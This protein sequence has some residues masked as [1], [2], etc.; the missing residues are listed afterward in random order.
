MLLGT[1]HESRGLPQS[2]ASRVRQIQFTD[3]QAHWMLKD[4]LNMTNT[5][6]T[7]TQADRLRNSIVCRATPSMPVLNV[8]ELETE[9]ASSSLSLLVIKNA[10]MLLEKSGFNIKT[11]VKARELVQEALAIY[12]I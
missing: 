9:A 7:N 5:L 8:D 2:R 11:D 3:M 1:S 10:L 6:L 12:S 4:L